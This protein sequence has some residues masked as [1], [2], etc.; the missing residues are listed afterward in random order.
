[1]S[2]LIFSNYTI[3]IFGPEW[4]NLEEIVPLF[5][6]VGWLST[7][8]SINSIY[9]Q[10]AGIPEVGVKYSMIRLLVIG[11]SFY[12]L[13]MLFNVKGVVIALLIGV[14]LTLL[15]IFEDVRRRIDAT[16]AMIL[17][18]IS[19]S[20]IPGISMIVLFPVISSGFWIKDLSILTIIAILAALTMYPKIKL[21]LKF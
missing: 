14:G 4:A 12:P 21:C 10:S 13:V 9:F 15:F 8:Y 16:R 17:W 2:Y 1:M 19:A 7:I 3:N 11:I 20:V 5:A 18:Q 6:L